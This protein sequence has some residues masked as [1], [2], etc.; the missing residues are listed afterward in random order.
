ML[1]DRRVLIVGMARS[2]RAAAELCRDH[3]ASVT[4]VDLRK[5]VPPIPGC[6]LHLGPHRREDFLNAELIVL[7]PGVSP[8]QADVAH[9]REAGVPV[10]GEFGLAASFLKA[11]VIAVTGTNGKS[12]VT[13]FVGQWLESLGKS[14]FVG[15]NLGRPLSE[16]V[17]KDYDVIVAEVSSYQLETAGAFT[18]AAAAVLNLAPDHLARHETMEN[19]GAVK[20]SVFSRM[21]PDAPA[22]LPAD[23]ALLIRLAAGTGGRRLWLGDL[24][25]ARVEDEGICFGWGEDSYQLSLEGFSVPGRHNRWNAAA[26][27]L[28]LTGVG[29]S[30]D[31]LDVGLLSALPHRME[32]VSTLNDV[33]WVN[34]SKA[35]NVAAAAVGFTSLDR[36]IVALVGGQAKA[37]DDFAVLRSALAQCREVICFGASGPMFADLVVEFRPH[38]VENLERAVHRANALSQPGDAVLLSPAGASF[39][40]FDN[41]EH[42]GDVFRE[43]V[44]A[45]ARSPMPVMEGRQNG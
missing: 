9:A 10:I 17:G 31:A 12:T 1:Q 38:C 26:A 7:S 37:G 20:C 32:P 44:G 23:D 39:D 21:G 43:L 33:L 3:G 14:T 2:G 35:T 40:A 4:C 13:H 25:G 8:T 18:P 19:Y 15:G 36:P 41:F 45:L 27:A 29:V 24:P 22:V 16:A 28:L 30:P 5:D 11:P 6:T 34:D 42:R